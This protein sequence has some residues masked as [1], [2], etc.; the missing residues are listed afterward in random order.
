MKKYRVSPKDNI[1]LKEWDP[2]ETSEFSGNKAAAKE[3]LQKLKQELDG[4]QELL[5]AESK[6]K[7][8]VVLQGMDTSGKDGT[9][10]SI[11]EGMN[12]QGVKVVA[13]KVP[14]PRI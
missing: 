8:L 9:I 11:F 1:K 4:L 10:R 2:N 12:P 5:Y 6:H 13:F 14:S 7:V 3:R